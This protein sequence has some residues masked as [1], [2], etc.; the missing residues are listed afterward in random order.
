M[1]EWTALAGGEGWGALPSGWVLDRRGQ[2]RAEGWRPNLRAAAIYALAARQ[3]A[4]AEDG[5]QLRLL[6]GV[7]PECLRGEGLSAEDVPTAFGS[8]DLKARRGRLGYRVEIGGGARP[9]GGFRLSWPCGETPIR[10]DLN[11][12]T[13]PEGLWDEEGIRLP[14]D[15]KGTVSA[16]FGEA[17]GDLRVR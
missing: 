1:F 12:R 4:V 13:L 11:G 10:V 8:L 5:D 16:R 15:F 7:P 3:M 6:E 17:M 14:D 2:A 9:P